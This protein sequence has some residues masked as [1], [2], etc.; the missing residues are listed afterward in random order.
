[1]KTL[2]LLACA[3]LLGCPAAP[4]VEETSRPSVAPADPPP[5]TPEPTPQAEAGPDRAPALEEA[6]LSGA[7][8]VILASNTEP[9]QE[10]AGLTRILDDATLAPGARPGRLD[11]SHFKGLMPCYEVVVATAGTDKAEAL[12]VSRTLKAAGIDHYV[13]NAGAY[14]GE[15]PAVDAHCA[16]QRA[17]QAASCPGSLRLAER[18]GGAVYVDMG[19]KDE[20]ASRALDTAG[21]ATSLGG[22]GSAW[23][24]PLTVQN[25]DDL[26]VGGE[27]AVATAAGGAPT[28]CSV[29]RFVALTRGTP[30]WGWS[31]QQEHT[32][33]GCGTAEVFAELDCDLADVRLASAAPI[34]ARATPSSDP[35]QDPDPFVS[36]L[37][38]SRAW[39]EASVEAKRAAEG[40][41]VVE[42]MTVT[43]W[44]MG[45]RELYV[46]QGWLRTGDGFDE[47]GGDEVNIVVRGVMPATGPVPLVPFR[48]AT[49]EEWIGLFDVDADGRLDVISTSFPGT[50]TIHRSDGEPLCFAQ[51]AYCDC[52]C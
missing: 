25:L 20:V 12:E 16:R 5:P 9:G 6:K 48:L 41:P 51:I 45:E 50:T 33:P 23:A 49:R 42:E 44:T 19:L 35:V 21:S 34:P 22:D 10:P 4:P 47:C 2:T 28:R 40:T 15:R 36:A 43:R 46:V 31:E 29:T 27:V 17:G 18:W 14:V 26:S 37:R 52:P 39:A 13:K 3:L 11:S 1:M 38:T 30:H 8:L 32:G 7:W 24:A